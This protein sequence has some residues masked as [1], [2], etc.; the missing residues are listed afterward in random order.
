VNHR[1]AE[2][3]STTFDIVFAHHRQLHP[4]EKRQLRALATL[5]GTAGLDAAIR[6]LLVAAGDPAFREMKE[7]VDA[8][9]DEVDAILWASP[10]YDPARSTYL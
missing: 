3:L 6:A 5:P 9:C 4:G 1:V 7:R 2:V 8:V 10:H